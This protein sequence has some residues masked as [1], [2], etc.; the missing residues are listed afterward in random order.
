MNQPIINIKIRSITDVITNSSSETFIISFPKVSPEDLK[1]LLQGWKKA[2]LEEDS[3]S[4]MAGEIKV[5]SLGDWAE[6]DR[7]DCYISRIPWIPDS[8]VVTIDFALTSTIRQFKEEYPEAYNIEEEVFYPI[9]DDEGKKILKLTPDYQE[10][11]A[12]GDPLKMHGE[13]AVSEMDW[14]NYEDKN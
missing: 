9:Y 6:E 8:L 4:G 12:L 1:K 13:W 2:F 3:Y 14:W 10:W 7:K 5:N 11:K